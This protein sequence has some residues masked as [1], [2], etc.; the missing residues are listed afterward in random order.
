MAVPQP[1]FYRAASSPSHLLLPLSSFPLVP[2]L[3]LLLVQRIRTSSFRSLPHSF[4]LP[5]PAQ[6]SPTMVALKAAALAL[7]LL[8][9]APGSHAFFR[10]PL[11]NPVR[12]DQF[13][14]FACP[15][16][17]TELSFPY[18]RCSSSSSAP[19]PSS[20]PAL[21]RDMFTPSRAAATFETQSRTKSSAT[22]RAPAP[23]P[24]RTSRRTGVLNCTGG[25]RTTR[26]RPFRRSA[27]A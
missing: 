22:R 8:C 13:S 2:E 26:S 20:A 6:S 4:S 5:R 21:S 1:P 27:A 19:I 25:T 24:S 15:L 23:A 16:R 7:S 3:D 10:M 12:V 18:P 17:R 9:A 11:D 14:P